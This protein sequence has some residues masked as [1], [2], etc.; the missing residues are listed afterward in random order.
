MG[1]V[2][3]FIRSSLFLLVPLHYL[4]LRPGLL[5]ALCLSVSRFS[6]SLLLFLSSSIQSLPCLS[7]LLPSC[8]FILLFRP[9]LLHLSF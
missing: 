4:F 7:G 6:S 5:Q 9:I 3:L 8:L 2:S 1:T